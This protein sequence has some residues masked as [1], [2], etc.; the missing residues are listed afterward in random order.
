M[1]NK[2]WTKKQDPKFIKALKNIDDSLAQLS[3]HLYVMVN[4]FEQYVEAIQA[5]PLYASAPEEDKNDNEYSN[6]TQTFSAAAE[7]VTE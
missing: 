2:T 1:E 4:Y 7:E 5:S 6:P 3:T